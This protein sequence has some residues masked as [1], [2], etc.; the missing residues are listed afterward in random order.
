MRRFRGIIESPTAPPTDMI[1]ILNHEFRYYSGGKWLLINNPVNLETS[2]ITSPIIKV[3]NTSEDKANNLSVCSEYST[4]DVVTMNIEG[5]LY[6]K[7]YDVLGVYHNGTVSILEGNHC[8]VFDVNFDTGEVTL[9]SRYDT[10][11][12]LPYIILE[13]GNSDE[14]KTINLERLR[15]QSVAG[16]TA[17]T[18]FVGIDYGYGVGTWNP[19][20]GG[21]AHIVTAY[22]NTVYYN[23]DKDGS[24]TK[25]LESPDIYL[26]YK[27]L[28]GTKSSEEF[29]QELINLF[30]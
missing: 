18:F 22:G 23:I 20:S 28:G 12:L 16:V 5:T 6:D 11:Q 7:Y 4:S 10:S 14:F 27:N 21:Q 13:I 2:G 25:A 29:I 17:N 26:E 3:G 1:W 8:T 19:T 30:D 9:D 15:S 24:V